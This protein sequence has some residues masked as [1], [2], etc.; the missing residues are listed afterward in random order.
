[1]MANQD[2]LI[3]EIAREVMARLEGRPNGHAAAAA[4]PSP[5]GVFATVDSAVAAAA[6]AQQ[7][8]AAMSLDERGRMCD[9]IRRICRDSA[10]ELARMELAETKLG[11]L[12]HK[13]VKLQNIRY[14]LG[15]ESMS[16]EAMT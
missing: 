11:R 3:A 5:D 1:M 4:P 14:V 7:R 2:Q 12:D 16:S 13:I 6:A 9:I 8:V 10:P 15:P